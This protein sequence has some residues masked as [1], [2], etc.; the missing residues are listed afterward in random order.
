MAKIEIIHPET[1]YYPSFTE[2]I[3]AR[4][5]GRA[6]LHSQMFNI[7]SGGNFQGDGNQWL[8]VIHSVEGAQI[9]YTRNFL[10]SSYYQPGD[11]GA[12]LEHLE[13]LAEKGEGEFG[14]GDMLPETSVLLTF[15]N[16]TYGDEDDPTTV[17]YCNLKIS[18]DTGAVFG[19]DAPGSRSADI[20]IQNLSVEEGVRFMSE[21]ILE[22]EAAY[23]GKHPDPASFPTGLSEWPFYEQLNR[24]AYNRL[25]EEYHEDYFDSKI[26]AVV[27]DDWLEQLPAGGHI[28]DAGCGHGDPVT[29]YMLAKGF[30]VT[31][32]DLSPKMLQRAR[33]QFPQAQFVQ[34]TITQINDT[35]AYDGICSFN[36]MLY[37][38]LIDFLNGINRMHRALKPGGQ[39]FLYGFDAGPGWRGIPFGHRIDQWMWSWHYGMGEAAALLE[40]H[41]YFEVLDAQIVSADKSEAK[42]LDKAQKKREKEKEAFIKKHV[43]SISPYPSPKA[44]YAY[45]IIARRCER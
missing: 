22:V 33:Q 38:D 29:G 10:H 45:A 1:E 39:L 9:F 2:T 18:T 21:L 25:S 44:P 5:W 15:D 19:H 7:G 13:E 30:Q 32:S 43:G 12:M 23:E 36:S 34:Q 8:E 37:L 3:E 24:Q 31:G 27:F 28:M 16:Y 42:R 4:V 14:F 35:A 20:Q 17:I 11:P 6:A 40:E 41:G 26:L